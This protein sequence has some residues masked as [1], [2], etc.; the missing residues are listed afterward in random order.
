MTT[1]LPY[2]PNQ[3]C[4][5]YA[6]EPSK[7]CEIISTHIS[8]K[9]YNW[10]ESIN[11]DLKYLKELKVIDLSNEEIDSM[12]SLADAEK[13]IW[14]FKGNWV[15]VS[16]SCIPQDIKEYK[17]MFGNKDNASNLHFSEEDENKG[18]FEECPV[19]GTSP[20]QVSTII[21]PQKE[22]G[23]QE[24]VIVSNQEDKTNPSA[25]IYWIVGI[26]VVIVIII[27]VLSFMRKKK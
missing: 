1:I 19:W 14:K 8:P 2:E 26:V 25:L 6:F 5:D 12:S 21:L 10:K 18:W 16:I 17:Q 3:A 9:D 24:N 23:V 27:L 4:I 13:S 15:Q 11:T 7:G 22:Y 20:R